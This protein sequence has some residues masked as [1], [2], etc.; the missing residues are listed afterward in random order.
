MPT[1]TNLDRAIYDLLSRSA[2]WGRPPILGNV[3]YVD[4]FAGDDLNDGRTPDRPFATIT[5]ALTQCVAD[6]DDYIFVMDLW[7]EVVT[8]NVARVHLI[9]VGT[10]RSHPFCQ[11]NAAA[12]TSC[13]SL[14]TDS[15][16]V[17]IAGFSFGGGATSAG[18]EQAVGA[19]MGVYIHDC[20]FGSFHAGGTPQDG[21]RV[22]QNITSPRIEH[23]TFLGAD[24]ATKTGGLLLRDGIRIVAGTGTYN[25]AIANNR[26]LGI[27]GVSCNF[28]PTSEPNGLVIEGNYFY[29]PIVDALAAGWAITLGAA[30]EGC[31][32]NNNHA[33]QTGDGTGANPYRDL[34]NVG[35]IA[36]LE[37]GWGM[38]YSGQAVIAPVTV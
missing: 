26:F 34:S 25:G 11:W 4:Q 21:I 30:A 14:N 33:M 20:V 3:F 1:D 13:I 17:E 22:T 18:I 27:P 2:F 12:D 9:G 5:F 35:L 24:A 37:N 6:H 28:T 19:C 36:Q 29:I 31:M 16:N 8:L 23:C 10:S 32:V 7:Q 15:N 38:N